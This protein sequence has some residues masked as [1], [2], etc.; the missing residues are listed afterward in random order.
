MNAPIAGIETG[1]ALASLF[2]E[3]PTFGCQA[4]HFQYLIDQTHGQAERRTLAATPP[5]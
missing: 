4:L 2:H 1:A 3:N 5:P